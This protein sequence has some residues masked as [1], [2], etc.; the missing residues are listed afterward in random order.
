MCGNLEF[1][2]STLD[3]QTFLHVFSV[4]LLPRTPVGHDLAPRACEARSTVPGAKSSSAIGCV[5]TRS[6]ALCSRSAG[7]YR[8]DEL[9]ATTSEAHVA[10]GF[11][12]R[13]WRQRDRS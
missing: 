9:E 3:H 13:P 2:V 5:E 1:E 7:S 10:K 4:P 11:D 8:G 6:I 12:V